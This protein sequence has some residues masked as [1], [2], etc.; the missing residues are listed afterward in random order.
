MRKELGEGIDHL[1]M[2]AE[3]AAAG[4]GATVGPR[5]ESAKGAV[6]PGMSKVREGTAQGWDSTVATLVPL[7]G[8]ARGAATGAGKRATNKATKAAAKAALAAGAVKAGSRLTKSG[9]KRKDEPKQR[10]RGPMLVGLLAVGTAVGA[11]AALLV[12][13]RNQAR[14]EEY[15]S[16]GVQAVRDEA[17]SAMDRTSNAVQQGADKVAT[18][19]EK[20]SDR[21]GNLAD[22]AKSGAATIAGKT[23]QA[24]DA[25]AA[26]AGDV[27]DAGKSRTD[28]LT[29]RATTA[30]KPNRS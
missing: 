6:S 15:E 16:Q 3:H 7:V 24:A 2:A 8:A 22:S 1:R 14:W 4:V 9:S 30:P 13:R 12:R 19:A 10:K 23:G 17:K 18:T 25:A 21:V 28:Q 11:A 29:N 27:A 26:R 20:A 5:M